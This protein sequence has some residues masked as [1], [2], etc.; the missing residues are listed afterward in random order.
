MARSFR[1]RVGSQRITH[2]LRPSEAG[3]ARAI[4][5]QMKALEDSI[6]AVINELVDV[7]PDVLDEALRPTF[8]KSQKYV[9]VQTGALKASGYLNVD[10]A[11]GHIRVEIGYGK[12]G[13]PFYAPY[14]HERMDLHHQ[15]PTKAKF[16][17]SAIEEDA[18]AIPQRIRI[19]Y[20]Q[21]MGL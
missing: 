15:A 7:T 20:K 21:R 11:Y 19:G 3:Y 13:D 4:R 6:S 10:Q 14:V 9:P 16:L 17:Q 8:E 2:N 5:Q 12:A 1:A 18:Q